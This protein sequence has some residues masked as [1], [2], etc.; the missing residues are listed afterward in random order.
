[1]RRIVGYHSVKEAL[2][3]RPKKV[4]T[5]FFKEGYDKSDQLKEMYDWVRSRGIPVKQVSDSF[6][7]D[8]SQTH[9]GVGAEVTE[10]PELD[11]ESLKSDD[12]RLV[13]LL[14]SV[15]DPHNFGAIIRTSW[16]M[17]AAAVIVPKDRSVSLTPTASKSASGGVEHVPIE[18]VTNLSE[19]ISELKELGFWTYGLGFEN[20]KGL[21]EEEF[22]AKVAL[23]LGAEGSGLREKTTKHC[24]IILK[25]AQLAPDASYNVSVS[26]GIAMAEVRRQWAV[27]GV[28]FD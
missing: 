25:I 6:L 10:S 20:S 21:W 19:T 3:V 15:V 8:L 11:W 12:N 13:V 18:T 27:A 26:A 23:V 24:D 5:V 2:K 28:D 4:R 16:L 17:G 7:K 1:M 9:Q 22:P 14:D